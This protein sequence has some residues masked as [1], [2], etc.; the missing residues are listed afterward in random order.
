MPG[1][2][3]D[4]GR[5]ARGYCVGRGCSGGGRNEEDPAA[6]MRHPNGPD[7]RLRREPGTGE[8]QWVQ[9]RSHDPDVGACRMLRRSALRD[10][11]LCAQVEMVS[12]LRRQ[13]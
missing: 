10:V 1:S 9:I 8:G 12:R 2:D 7:G 4:S 13:A 6:V 11:P 3:S 5:R